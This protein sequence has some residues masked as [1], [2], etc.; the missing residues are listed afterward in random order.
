MD[1]ILTANFASNGPRR[2]LES[3]F[4]AISDKRETVRIGRGQKR[5]IGCWFPVSARPAAP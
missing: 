2:S 5:K 1:N 4:S 3:P